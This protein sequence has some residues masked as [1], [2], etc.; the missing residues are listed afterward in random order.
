LAP[1]GYVV[2]LVTVPNILGSDY[3]QWADSIK[4][5]ITYLQAQNSGS[6]TLAGMIS[7]VFGAAGH[8]MGADGVL[9]AAEQDSRI[10][11]VISMA[12]SSPFNDS[13]AQYI[14]NAAGSITAATMLQATADDNIVIP[15]SS[16]YFYPVLTCPK[17]FINIT[18][19]GDLLDGHFL[20]TDMG[21][22][23]P[24]T[25]AGATL[26]KYTSNWFDYYLKGDTSKYTDIFGTRA[27]NDLAAGALSA[28]ELAPH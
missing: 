12:A 7:G 14:Y 9:L 26:L 8:S 25:P 19:D 5:G 23:D 16:E 10:K 28:L 18:P 3:Q 6:S 4:D 1:G 20:Y 13:T 22:S 2:A 24:Q 21:Q 15:A 27:Q 11:A 17:E